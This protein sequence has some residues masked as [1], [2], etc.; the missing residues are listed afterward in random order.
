LAEISWRRE[1]DRA[2]EQPAGAVKIR[3]RASL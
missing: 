2:R 1:R 3:I